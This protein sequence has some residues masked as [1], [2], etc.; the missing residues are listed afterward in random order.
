MGQDPLGFSQ[1]TNG[2]PL[3]FQLTIPLRTTA[4]AYDVSAMGTADHQLVASP[5][6]SLQV[7]LP[8]KLVQMRTEP[9]A[10][11]FSKAGEVV[12]LHVIAAAPDGSHDDVTHSV[13]IKCSSE[14]MRVVTVD[15]DCVVAAVG[16][17][18][19]HVIVSN[20]NPSS[21]YYVSTEVG[22]LAQI[23]NLGLAQML[24]GSSVTFHWLGS[25]TATAF[26][27]DVGSTQGGYD[28]Y[29]SDS[30]SR[31]TLSQTVDNLPTDGRN[32]YVTL[33]SMIDGTWGYNEYYYAA[34]NREGRLAREPNAGTK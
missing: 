28:Y 29:H 16:L 6:I 27:I 4:G 12:P 23:D 9:S 15:K 26:R 33:W 13:Q 34:F 22:N 5:A 25:N 20:S 30:L 1:T 19:T 24:P 3:Q 10:L 8:R 21:Q 31:M 17:G 32:I 18:S 14:N 11:R 7:E 2:Q